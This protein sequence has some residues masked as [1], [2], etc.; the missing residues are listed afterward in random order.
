[1]VLFT[2]NFNLQSGIIYGGRAEGLKGRPVAAAEIFYY[3]V[4]CGTNRVKGTQGIP[5]VGV[6][7][8]LFA[9]L[10]WLV[11]SLDSRGA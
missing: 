3:E 8:S 1:M 4:V 5:V 10:G 2:S 7:L 9:L 6:L 11:I